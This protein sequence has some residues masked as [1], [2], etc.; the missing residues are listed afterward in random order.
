M[1]DLKFFDRL[2]RIPNLKFLPSYANTFDLIDQSEFVATV[3]GTVGWEAIRKGKNAL[4]FGM[5]WYLNLPGVIQFHNGL[6]YEMILGYK[7]EHSTLEQLT[8][9]LHSRLHCADILDSNSVAE[10]VANLI[11]NRI[12]TTFKHT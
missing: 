5:P 10:S 8:G 3:T 1:R 11:E 9:E 7:I 4:V 12:E 2:D 6:T